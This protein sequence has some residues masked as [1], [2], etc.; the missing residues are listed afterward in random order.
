MDEKKEGVKREA[1]IS[2][3]ESGVVCYIHLHILTPGLNGDL[4]QGSCTM[5][6]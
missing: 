2:H 1:Y 5:H 3:A 6:V 4:Q